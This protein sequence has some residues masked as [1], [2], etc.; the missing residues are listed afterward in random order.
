VISLLVL[1]QFADRRGMASSVQSSLGSAGNAAVAGLLVPLLMHSPLALAWAALAMMVG[2]LLAWLWV[3][4][5][6]N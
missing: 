2:G 3:Q 6:V 1:D 5:R 4:P